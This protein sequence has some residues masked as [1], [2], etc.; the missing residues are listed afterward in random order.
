MIHR[1]NVN[2]YVTVRLTA[3]GRAT[4]VRRRAEWSSREHVPAVGEP[5][6]VQLWCL[7]D[8]LGPDVWRMGSSPYLVDNVIEWAPTPDT[9]PNPMPA[10]ALG[11]RVWTHRESDGTMMIGKIDVESTMPDET[12]T[13]YIYERDTIDIITD[14]RT[15]EVLWRR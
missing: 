11:M 4:V 13:D 2:N 6:R 15:G 10:P 14:F 3:D 8:D 1:I 9:T 7:L 12:W 5:W